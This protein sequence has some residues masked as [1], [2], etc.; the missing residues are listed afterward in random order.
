VEVP[1]FENVNDNSENRWVVVNDENC[2][3]G[4]FGRWRHE[5]QL[6]F[7]CAITDSTRRSIDNRARMSDDV[8][9]NQPAR[10]L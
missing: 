3:D 9:L 8:L 10:L 5:A 6:S 2:F 1:P 4:Y 7:V